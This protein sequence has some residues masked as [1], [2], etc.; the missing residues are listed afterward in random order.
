MPTTTTSA[1]ETVWVTKITTA[2]TTLCPTSSAI[3][4]GDTTSILTYIGTS[5][6][7]TTILQTI[8]KLVSQ[9]SDGQVQA[10]GPTKSSS[11][12]S[13][14]VAIESS[15]VADL[16]TVA[17]SESLYPSTT[18]AEALPPVNTQVGNSNWGTLD[19]GCFP[20]WLAKA[21]GTP[22]V[23]APWGNFSTKNADAT[24]VGNVPKTGVTR[25]YEFTVSRGT[26]AP[27]G[28]LRDVILING[29]Y[30]GYGPFPHCIVRN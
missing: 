11:T 6:V 25:F 22:Y 10:P 3:V 19:T 8:T 7:E 14:V 20:K 24:V 27:D 30:V 15:A 5:S 21:D 18:G 4:D 28:V 23:S 17:V 2:F 16:S 12:L 13:S 29:Q 1:N 26:I 9:I